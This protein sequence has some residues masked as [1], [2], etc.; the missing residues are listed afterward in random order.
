MGLIVDF[1]KLHYETIGTATQ[2]GTFTSS[3]TKQMACDF[4]RSTKWKL[5]WSSH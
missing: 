1:S 3:E 5:F 2:Q 4:Y